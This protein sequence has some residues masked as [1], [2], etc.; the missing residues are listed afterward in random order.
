MNKNS[1]KKC[2]RQLDEATEA[3]ERLIEHNV[4]SENHWD[5]FEDL[6]S[7]KNDIE[8]VTEVEIYK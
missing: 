6:V 7:L 5:T 2:W 3:I 4:I 1:V 8:D